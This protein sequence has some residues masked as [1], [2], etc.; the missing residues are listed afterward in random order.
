MRTAWTDDRSSWNSSR[1]RFRVYGVELEL[2]GDLVHFRRFLGRD[3]AIGGGDNEA[4]AEDVDPLL[5]GR[6][7]RELPGDDVVLG[8][9][10]GAGLKLGHLGHEHGGRLVERA[11]L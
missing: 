8:T 3:R 1:I 11:A 4:R 2:L 5:F 9:A 7:L 6:K 10:D